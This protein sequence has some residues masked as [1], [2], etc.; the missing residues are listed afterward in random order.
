[1]I[2]KKRFLALGLAVTIVATFMPTDVSNAKTK[3]PSLAGKK[4]VT[5]KKSTTLQVK[6][7]GTKIKKVTWKSSNKKIVT[8]KTKGK[9]ACKITGV[10]KGNAKVTATVSYKVGKKSLKKKL[11]CKVTVKAA[12]ANVKATQTPVPSSTPVGTVA[13]SS[14]PIA[15][16]T[17]APA[18][19]KTPNVPEEKVYAVLEFSDEKMT[20]ITNVKNKDVATYVEIPSSVTSIG[21]FAFCDCEKLESITIPN[22]VARTAV[23]DFAFDGCTSLT[24]VTWH[25]T[26]Y[27]IQ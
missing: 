4:T 19:T 27:K 7:N 2:N 15:T 11:T 25:G 6:A 3:V 1:M 24:W 21:G 26:T 8:V 10:K 22:N 13:P 18:A 14:T 9:L 16:E 5:V 12:K 17:A 20:E 23:D